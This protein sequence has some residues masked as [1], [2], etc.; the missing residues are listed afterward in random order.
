MGPA[1]ERTADADCASVV[2]DDLAEQTACANDEMVEEERGGPPR[3]QRRGAGDAAGAGHV[4]EGGG[5]DLACGAAGTEGGAPAGAVGGDE[6]ADVTGAAMGD[7][8][9]LFS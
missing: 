2:P 7:P 6:G 9:L 5:E 8:S 1:T 4:A 3:P